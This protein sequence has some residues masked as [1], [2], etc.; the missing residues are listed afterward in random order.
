M[1]M[2]TYVVLAELDRGRVHPRVGSDLVTKFFVLGGS[3]WVGSSVKN[4]NKSAIYT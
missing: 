4:S 1:R 2:R 3:G